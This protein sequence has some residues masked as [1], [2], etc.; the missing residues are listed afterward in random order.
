MIMACFINT[1]CHVAT[2]LSS[3]QHKTNIYII[4]HEL[5]QRARLYH[6][7][8]SSAKGT[9]VFRSLWDYIFSKGHFNPS[10]GF[11]ADRNIKKHN[12]VGHVVFGCLLNEASE[13]V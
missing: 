13:N 12:W 6:Y 1:L 9:E 5:R 2:V 4:H 11:S 10:C 8:L 7:L 3:S